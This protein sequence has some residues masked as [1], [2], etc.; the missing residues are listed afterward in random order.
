MTDPVAES[1][2]KLPPFEFICT[3]CKRKQL[4]EPDQLDDAPHKRPKLETKSDDDDSL[5]RLE[6]ASIK[7]ECVENDN[8]GGDQ[9]DEPRES[10]EDELRESA[11]FHQI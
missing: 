3:S 1:R 6:I 8:E 4:F 9:R 10:A 11:I 2:F 5:A 7:K